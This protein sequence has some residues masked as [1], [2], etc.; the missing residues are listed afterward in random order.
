MPLVT[1][2]GVLI[3]QKRLPTK[4]RPISLQR[5]NKWLGAQIATQ[6]SES[7]WA[8][9]VKHATNM[10]A[11]RHAELDTALGAD[12]IALLGDPS[13]KDGATV[14]RAAVGTY[15]LRNEKSESPSREGRLLVV[16][17]ARRENTCS[18]TL[19]GVV[20]DIPGVLDVASHATPHTVYAACAEDSLLAFDV[21]P[22]EQDPLQLRREVRD[23]EDHR[24]IMLSVDVSEGAEGAQ[25]P[26]VAASDSTGGVS[27]YSALRRGWEPVMRRDTHA[28][29][30]WSV[31]VDGLE[32]VLYSGGDDGVLVCYDWKSEIERFRLGTAHEGVGVTAV[33]KDRCQGRE[34]A[35]F[36]LWTGGYDDT[37]RLWDVRA[38]KGS[39]A[40][41][42]VGG[43]V[44]RVRFHPRKRGLLLLATMYDGFKIVRREEGSDQ[45][46]VACHYQGHQSLA[47]GATWVPSLDTGEEHVAMTGSFYDHSLQLWTIE[48]PT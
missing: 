32:G 7:I 36:Q 11:V 39:V 41:V 21:R 1:L 3:H 27:L 15:S 34:E 17:A 31:C 28:E 8:V 20:R 24:R 23:V 13:E 6:Q 44:W 47:Y 12:S 5:R 16:S 33:T 29:E 30:A 19:D 22:E 45:L 42:G 2:G 18:L 9:K 25:P 26:F 14:Q 40:E 10:H 37:L 48:D 46:S 4:E 35:E 38:M 43:G